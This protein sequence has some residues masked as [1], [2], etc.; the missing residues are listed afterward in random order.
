MVTES[1]G[2]PVTVSTM[3]WCSE[4]K[5]LAS[6]TVMVPGTTS[7]SK[8]WPRTT[9]VFSTGGEPA[10]IDSADETCLELSEDEEEEDSEKQSGGRKEKEPWLQDRWEEDRLKH[11][12]GEQ[13]DGEE[14]EKE[15]K[16]P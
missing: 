12:Q 1:P 7:G 10:E 11:D 14:E 2:E 13:Q 15:M 5:T 4:G 16:E 9:T 6:V 8:L 3:K